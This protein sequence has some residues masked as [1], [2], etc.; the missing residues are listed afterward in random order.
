MLKQISLLLVTIAFGVFAQA[1]SPVSWSFSSKKLKDGVYE[2]HFTASVQNGWTIYSQ[3]TPDGGPLPTSF[4]FVKN[5][6]LTLDGKVQEPPTMKKKHEEVFGVD[7]HYFTDRVDF[8]QIVKVK[9]KAK[10]K[11]TGTLEYMAC[12][13]EQC[14]PPAEVE[15]SIPLN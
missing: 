9:G 4:K 3:T 12:D 15:F 8:V 6:L 1:Q 11:L 14:L 5:P 2:V 13:N 10:T 7:V